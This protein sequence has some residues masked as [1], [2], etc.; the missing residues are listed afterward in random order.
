MHAF[1]LFA[2]TQTIKITPSLSTRLVDD[3]QKKELRIHSL[4]L[5]EDKKNALKYFSKNFEL[6]FSEEQD[7]T[8]N[9]DDSFEDFAKNSK[10]TLSTNNLFVRELN[11]TILV[12]FTL[13]ESRLNQ[14]YN[15]FV[16][17]VWTRYN[18]DY[19]LEKR[20]ISP[21]KGFNILPPGFVSQKVIVKKY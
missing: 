7:H 6:I 12:N 1:P 11:G 4:L 18:N 15:W 14:H 10:R 3:F 8:S 19:R 13:Q 9:L 17:D 16:V 5:T 21:M 2:E 20:Y